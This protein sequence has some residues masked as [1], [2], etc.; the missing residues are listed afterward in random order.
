MEKTKPWAKLMRRLKSALALRLGDPLSSSRTHSQPTSRPLLLSY[1]LRAIIFKYVIYSETLSL[2]DLMHALYFQSREGLY[3]IDVFYP[4][5]SRH[6][7]SK[8]LRI[9]QIHDEFEVLIFTVGIRM[10]VRDR[11]KWR[12]SNSNG[13]KISDTRQRAASFQ[14]FEVEF[15]DMRTDPVGFSSLSIEIFVD[16]E[17]PHITFALY[18]TIATLVS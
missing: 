15:Q 13:F 14:A 8:L 16:Y 4:Q 10:K 18:R 2:W 6:S 17:R 9:K 3:H 5:Y 12:K 1:E 11:Q 7:S